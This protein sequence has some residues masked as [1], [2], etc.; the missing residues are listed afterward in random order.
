MTRFLSMLMLCLSAECLATGPARAQQLPV[1][2]DEHA[3]SSDNRSSAEPLQK[4]L[5]K[6]KAAAGKIIDLGK[7]RVVQRGAKPEIIIRDGVITLLLTET[8]WSQFWSRIEQYGV[9]D[10]KHS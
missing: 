5:H 2:T 7:A 3:T 8:R 9:P 6:A 10:V 1:P 4:L